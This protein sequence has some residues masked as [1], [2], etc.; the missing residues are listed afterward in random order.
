MRLPLFLFYASIAVEHS[1]AC[2]HLLHS[3][4]LQEA[5][6]NKWKP[7]R[8]YGRDPYDRTMLCSVSI[9]SNYGY[10][11]EICLGCP[12][13]LISHEQVSGI[14]MFEQMTLSLSILVVL[15]HASSSGIFLPYQRFLDL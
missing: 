3:A 13:P 15:V 2:N 7:I 12:K 5:G 11:V 9:L 10:V 14:K 8:I 6:P 4:L 1:L